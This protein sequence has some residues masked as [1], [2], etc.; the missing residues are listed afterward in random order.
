MILPSWGDLGRLL[1]V[2]ILAYVALVALL[3]ISGKRTLTKLNAFDFVI[4]VAL[5]STLATIL[6]DKSISLIEG[7][8][9]LALLIV[10]QFAITS[11]SVRSPNFERLIKSEATLI[12][13]RGAFLDVQMRQERVTREDVLALLRSKGVA[14]LG[15]VDAVVLETNGSMSVLSSVEGP[16]WPSTLEDVKLVRSSGRGARSVEL[17]DG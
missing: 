2:G 3:R 16:G 11:V 5:G 15:S 1:F 8:L 9:G 13:H 6:L 14:E 12:V 17:E 10:L 7:V 4:T